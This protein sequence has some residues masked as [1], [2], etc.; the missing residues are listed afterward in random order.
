M[1][2]DEGLAQLLRDDL[3]DAAF[4]EQKMFG[5][6]A[7]LIGG[8]MV[9]GVHKG[10]AMFRVGK[11]RMDQALTLQGVAQMAMAGRAMTGMAECPPEVLAQDATRGALMALALDCVR[12]LPPKVAK[13]PK[14]R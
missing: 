5:G 11:E 9:C 13:A 3:G 14:T 8:N 6:L 2:Y 1:A 7:F 4:T 10:G 12:A